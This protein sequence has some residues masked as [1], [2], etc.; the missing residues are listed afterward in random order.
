M[1]CCA[2]VGVIHATPNSSSEA[3]VESNPESEEPE[4]HSRKQHSCTWPATA[5]AQTATASSKKKKKKSQSPSSNGLFSNMFRKKKKSRSVAAS[6]I[7]E[8]EMALEWDSPALGRKKAESERQM[9]QQESA[10]DRPKVDSKSWFCKTKWFTQMCDQAFAAIDADGSGNVDEKELYSGLLLI[11]LKLG[12][13][14]GPA[15]C[16]PLSRERAETVFHKFDV[17]G[18]GTLDKDEF[19]NVM[20]VLFGNVFFRVLVQWTL[21]LMVVPMVA[22][23]I[24]DGIVSLWM[25]VVSTIQSLDEQSELAHSIELTLEGAA[26][27]GTSQLTGLEPYTE[28]IGEYVAMVPESVWEAIPLGLV[29]TVLGIIVVPWCIFQ[30]DDFFQRVADKK[31]KED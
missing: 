27:W 1:G 5:M 19:Q 12:T 7:T 18:S 20:T 26:S 8:E 9:K 4:S 28:K 22:Q 15:A 31:S 6:V 25:F 11:H 3:H 21:T 29:S 30:V 2:N 14:A 16:R 23:A 10:R 13:Y 24:I 17:D